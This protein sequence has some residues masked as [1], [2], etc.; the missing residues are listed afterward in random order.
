MSLVRNHPLAVGVSSRREMDASRSLS[1]SSAASTSLQPILHSSSSSSTSP[2]SSLTPH[3]S[4]I[5]LPLV[6]TLQANPLAQPLRAQVAFDL[7]NEFPKAYTD[8]GVG[9]WA[10]YSELAS[11]A[12]VVE[13]GVGKVMGS[14]WV[15]LRREHREV[16]R[17]TARVFDGPSSA[18]SS[19]SPY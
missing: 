7:K 16:A 8:A 5:F 18:S 2:P 19:S 14:H 13:M 3:Q 10:S 4:K 1:S 15:C 17:K 12:G 9:G 6:K 11:R